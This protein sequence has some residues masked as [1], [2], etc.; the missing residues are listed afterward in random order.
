M[1]PE[2][3]RRAAVPAP[4]APTPDDP[5]PRPLPGKLA[6]L[7]PGPHR[8]S[9]ITAAVAA[10]GYAGDIEVEIFNES[11]WSAPPDET[12]ATVL[13]RFSLLTTLP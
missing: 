6:V 2:H 4:T 11:I 12:A 3:W 5:A 9:P 10:A 1:S 13:E 7:R 8:L